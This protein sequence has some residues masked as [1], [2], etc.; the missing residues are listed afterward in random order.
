M[1]PKK[2]WHMH[3]QPKRS[4]DDQPQANSDSF[5]GGSGN[6]NGD[7]SY[8]QQQQQQPSKR[9]RV[10]AMSLSN[11]K[12][13]QAVVG[14]CDVRNDRHATAELVD[15]LNAFADE[16]YPEGGQQEEGEEDEN[17]G[18][19]DAALAAPKAAAL[20]LKGLSLIHI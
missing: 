16:L 10:S 7:A 17:K 3:S 6:G 5:G 8:Q 14:T 20:G 19:I 4:R 12:G 18:A 13:H 11:V 15:L 1:G 9:A 2:K